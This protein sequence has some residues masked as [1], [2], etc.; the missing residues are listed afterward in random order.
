MTQDDETRECPYC[1]ESIKP[2]AIKCKHCLSWLGPGPDPTGNAPSTWDVGPEKGVSFGGLRRPRDDRMIAGVCSGIG[3]WI[4]VDPTLIR[5]VFAVV[6]FFT[7]GVP[8]IILYIIMALV[9]PNEGD[10]GIWTA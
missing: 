7:A 1:R 5:I 2:G 8:G 3:R 6:T 9:I 10:P 4:G